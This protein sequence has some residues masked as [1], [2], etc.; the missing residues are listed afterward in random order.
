MNDRDVSGSTTC[1]VFGVRSGGP[2][3]G[4][5]ILLILFGLIPLVIG[6]V[7]LPIPVIVVFIGFGV[8]LIWTG[9]TK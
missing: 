4:L 3:I 9:L 2:I 1:P 8:F 5:G 7:S 6:A